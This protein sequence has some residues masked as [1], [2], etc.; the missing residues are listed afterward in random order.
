MLKKIAEFWLIKKIIEWVR[1]RNEPPQ[2][3]QP[4]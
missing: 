1:G 2:P 3:P 4:A